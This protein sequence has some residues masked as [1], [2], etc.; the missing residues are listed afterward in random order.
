MP[1][2]LIIDDDEMFRAMLRE[3]L[4]EAHYDVEEAD[5]SAAG[6]GLFQKREFDLIITDLF[7]P[8]GGGL[9]VIQQVRKIDKKI[10]I[11]VI[12]GMVLDNRDEIFK[13]ALAAGANQTLEKP[14]SQSVLL[15]TVADLL[16]HVKNTNSG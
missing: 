10:G 5:S 16:S 12:S 6:V 7:M 13:H 14:V 4:E 1:R 8:P 3:M 9:G 11:V 2:I 15:Q